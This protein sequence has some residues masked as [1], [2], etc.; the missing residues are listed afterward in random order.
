MIKNIKIGRCIYISLTIRNI[1][2]HTYM[3]A[4]DDERMNRIREWWNALPRCVAIIP[5]SDGIVCGFK[6]VPYRTRSCGC[7]NVCHIHMCEH[8]IARVRESFPAREVE[9][10]R[11]ENEHFLE[12]AHECFDA[13]G[14]FIGGEDD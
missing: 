9:R 8:E 10:E 1:S 14:K 5:Y 6:C 13:D 7:V 2:F 3:S 4:N 11:L 12:V